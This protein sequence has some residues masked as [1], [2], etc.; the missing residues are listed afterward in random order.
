M[1]TYTES[2]ANETAQIGIHVQDTGAGYR[3]RLGGTSKA[4]PTDINW[5]A[6]VDELEDVVNLVEGKHRGQ[7]GSISI[8]GVHAAPTQIVGFDLPDDAMKSGAYIDGSIILNAASR[9]D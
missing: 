5:Q 8:R 7:I 1:T 4:E 6:I 2:A 9:P 3:V